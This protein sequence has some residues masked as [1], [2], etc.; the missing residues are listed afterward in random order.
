MD[1]HVPVSL[2]ESIV[3]AN[4]VQIVA[5]NDDGSL[6]FHFA[7]DTGQDT[8]TDRAHTSEGAFL[9]DVVSGD[10]LKVNRETSRVKNCSY[11]S[12]FE[13]KKFRIRSG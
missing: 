10:C 6:H 9:V 12:T 4:K 3:F 1:A 7:N 13:Y 11:F 5:T 2:L 8:S